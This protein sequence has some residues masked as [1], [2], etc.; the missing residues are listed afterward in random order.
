MLP[1]LHFCQRKKAAKYCV[2]WFYEVEVKCT[3]CAILSLFTTIQ[4]VCS[5]DR[6]HVTFAS[7]FLILCETICILGLPHLL[8]L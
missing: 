4:A 6:C 1:F 3:V 8:V 2:L 7:C 5:L